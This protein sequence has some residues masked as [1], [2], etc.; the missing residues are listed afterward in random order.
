MVK[1]VN[2]YVESITQDNFKRENGMA[3]VDMSSSIQVIPL[4]DHLSVERSMAMEPSSGAI[5]TTT[6]KVNMSKENGKDKERGLL[7]SLR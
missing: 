2:G 1:D 7:S 4:K 5:T 6:L 3:K